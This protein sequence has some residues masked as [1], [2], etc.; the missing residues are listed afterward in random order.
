MLPIKGVYE[1][2]I[3]VKDLARAELLY[4]RAWTEEGLRDERRNWLF[5][6]A[7]AM[8]AWSFCRKTNDWPKQHFAFTVSEAD[9]GAAEKY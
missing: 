3:R 5:L 4:R 8:P 1:I 7:A 6:F 9:L 2:A